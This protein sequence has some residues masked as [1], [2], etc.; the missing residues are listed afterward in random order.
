M[1]NTKV[2]QL[3]N[4]DAELW[5]RVKAQAALDDKTITQWVEDLV[6]RKLNSTKKN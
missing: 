5:R 2:Q 6:K 1:E 4:V 3:K